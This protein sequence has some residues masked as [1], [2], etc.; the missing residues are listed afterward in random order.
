MTDLQPLTSALAAVAKKLNT[1]P[2]L[3]KGVV[4]GTSPLLVQLEGDTQ[5]LSAAPWVLGTALHQGQKVLSISWGGNR[6]AIGASE[7]TQPTWETLTCDAG[8]GWT[9]HEAKTLATG[10]VWYLY[11]RVSSSSSFTADSQGNINDQ[12]IMT[13]PS[14]VPMPA[15]RWHGKWYRSGYTSGGVRLHPDTRE[16]K[17]IDGIPSATIDADDEIVLDLRWPV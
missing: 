12:T 9:I 3:R 4:V 2:Q 1:I 15:F 17:L 16:L 6:V 14:T 11:A 10:G 8:S 7:T 5:P 13:L